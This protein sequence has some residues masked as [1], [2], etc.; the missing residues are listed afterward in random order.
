[1]HGCEKETIRIADVYERDNWT[2]YL[3]GVKV[4]KSSVY[5]KDMATI[6]HVVPLVKG[7]SHTYGN[8]KTCCHSCNSKKKDKI[9]DLNQIPA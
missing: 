5:R 6:D 4:V 1:M 2:C 9:Y 3:C 8:V 7:G